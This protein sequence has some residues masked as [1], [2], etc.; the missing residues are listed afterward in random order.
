MS[1]DVPVLG[2]RVS[3]EQAEHDLEEAAHYIEFALLLL[4][5]A[6][7]C[8]VQKDA[9]SHLQIARANIDELWDL[10]RAN[11]ARGAAKRRRV[12]GQRK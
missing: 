7:Q 6:K 11:R 9:V 5:T 2:P 12:E 10:G 1:N 8:Q 4:S 3:F